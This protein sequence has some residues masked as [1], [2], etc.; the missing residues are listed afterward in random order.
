MLGFGQATTGLNSVQDFLTVRLQR[1][2]LNLSIAELNWWWWR[3]R[4]WWWYFQIFFFLRFFLKG[5]LGS[6]E[7]IHT[8]LINRTG[9]PEASVFPIHMNG[10]TAELW[11]IPTGILIDL[12]THQPESSF[13]LLRGG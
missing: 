4:C 9:A 5:T 8:G 7:E 2:Y 12:K 3:R 1:P 11:I 10:T 13:Y 6:N